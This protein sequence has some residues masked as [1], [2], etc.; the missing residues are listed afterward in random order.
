VRARRWVVAVV[1]LLGVVFAVGA[2][3]H[4]ISVGTS[5]SARPACVVSI[6][7]QRVALDQQQAT[8][9]MTIAAVARDLGLADHAVTIAN[10]A[11]MQES[12][13]RNLDHGDRDSLG[14][15]QQRPSQGWGT[16]AQLLDPRYAARAFLVR[17]AHIEGWQSLPVTVAAQRVQRSAT[18]TA[19]AHWELQARLIARA[20]TGEVPGA[21]RCQTPITAAQ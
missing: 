14:L 10:A 20:T 4:L 12:G 13:L 9:A 5:G 17:L 7:T 18:P 21:L 2:V 6:G 19:Y 15:F 11:A 16:P 1:L 8:N 3:T